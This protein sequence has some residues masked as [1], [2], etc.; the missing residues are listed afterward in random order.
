LRAFGILGKFD[1][2]L[3]ARY[4]ICFDLFDIHRHRRTSGA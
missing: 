4:Q 3:P 1:E 2:R